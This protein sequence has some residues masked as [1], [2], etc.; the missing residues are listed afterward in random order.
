MLGEDFDI[1]RTLK[2]ITDDLGTADHETYLE[3]VMEVNAPL[4]DE[5]KGHVRLETF[6]VKSNLSDDASKICLQPNWVHAS[7]LIGCGFHYRVWI[8]VGVMNLF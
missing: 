3:D 6:H 2:E 5:G 1:K 7:L 4:F 8:C